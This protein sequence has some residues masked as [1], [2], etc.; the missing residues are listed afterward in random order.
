MRFQTRLP[1]A[2]LLGVTLFATSA[3]ANEAAT[4][5]DVSAAR[6]AERI[7]ALSRFGANPEGGVSRVAFSQADIAGREYIQSLMREAALK[8][9]RNDRLGRCAIFLPVAN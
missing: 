3:Q 1:F 8:L 5:T 9:L 6:M 2:P 7:G 4:A